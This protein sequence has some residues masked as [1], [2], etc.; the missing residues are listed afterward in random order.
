[1]NLVPL[2]DNVI[3]KPDPNAKITKGG[4]H[5]PD[6]AKEAK[7]VNYGKILATGPGKPLTDAIEMFRGMQVKDG[8]YIMYGAYA[9]HAFE[10][11]GEKFVALEE[12]DIIAVVK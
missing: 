12:S 7:H 4:I 3:V 2:S 11:D 10:R 6:S 5:I 9:G 8:D 1:M